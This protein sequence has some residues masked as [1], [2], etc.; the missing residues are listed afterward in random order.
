MNCFYV[1]F[2]EPDILYVVKCNFNLLLQIKHF[3][4]IEK[5]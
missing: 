5:P 2:L 4:F 1:D 3:P